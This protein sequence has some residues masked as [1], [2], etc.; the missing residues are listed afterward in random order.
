[1]SK[2]LR[3]LLGIGLCVYLAWF[4]LP[5]IDYRWLSE[6]KLVILGYSTYGSSLEALPW[7]SWVFF[8]VTVSVFLISF[9]KPVFCRY[10]LPIYVTVSMLFFLA[11][12]GINVETAVSIFIRDLFNIVIGAL[13]AINCAQ[14]YR[15]RNDRVSGADT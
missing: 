15:A 1:M 9:A 2:P 8:F 11:F 10:I 14:F 7:I 3:A 5:L 6:D 13:L 12:G 4:L